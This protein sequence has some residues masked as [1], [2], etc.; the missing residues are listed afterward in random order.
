MAP[1]LYLGDDLEL[2]DGL[3]RDLGLEPDLGKRPP[4]LTSGEIPDSGLDAQ[5]IVSEILEACQVV[6][7]N[8]TR[9]IPHS[10][11][12]EELPRAAEEE[13]WNVSAGVIKY[14]QFV[15]SNS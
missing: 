6:S 7:L 15:L 5:V 12:S 2:W 14:V 10:T 4:D 11:P 8:S 13:G 9:S 3:A 1:L